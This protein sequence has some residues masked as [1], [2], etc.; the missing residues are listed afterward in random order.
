MNYK[1]ILILA[2]ISFAC[3]SLLIISN[4]NESSRNKIFDLNDAP[5]KQAVLVL[6]ARVW[7]NGEMSDIFKDRVQTAIDLYKSDKVEK[8][9]VSGDHG[10]K[11]YDEVNAAKKFLLEKGISPDDIFLD[12][13][14]FDTYDSLYRAKEVF[15][16]E[17]LI[18]STQDFHL[19]RALYIAEK[20]GID[21]CGVSSD[22]HRY[23]GEQQ[24][25]TRE[26]LAKIKA[27]LDVTFMA[28][29]KF[30]GEPIPLSGKGQNSWD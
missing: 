26:K 10:R 3:L 6:G 22:L 8:I 1:A 2:I 27:W 13:A 14:G 19:P 4:I 18:I 21:A 11:E 12:H 17:S 28:K 16:A 30:L 25:E 24:R 5:P 23:K 20:L 15:K 9:L 7:E 29:P